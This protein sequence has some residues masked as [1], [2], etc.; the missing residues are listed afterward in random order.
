MLSNQQPMIINQNIKDAVPV[1]LPAR[2]VP[3]LCHHL[4]KLVQ[5]KLQKEEPEVQ[6][7]NTRVEAA[8][9]E[10]FRVNEIALNDIKNSKRKSST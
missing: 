8:T 2:P 6:E 3:H 5:H 1:P 10:K 7:K 9:Q 4:A